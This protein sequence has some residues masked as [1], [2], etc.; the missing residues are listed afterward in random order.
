MQSFRCIFRS[1]FLQI[2]RWSSLYTNT[3]AVSINLV[4]IMGR[5]K[6]THWPLVGSGVLGRA[7]DTLDSKDAIGEED[8]E[9]KCD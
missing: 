9:Q 4:S 5:T 7:V 6:H 1:S 2:G 8:T 3:H